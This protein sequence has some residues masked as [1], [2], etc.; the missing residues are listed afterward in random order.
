M[1]LLMK[2]QLALGLLACILISYPWNANADVVTIS[3]RQ[4]LVNGAPYTI[5][6][7]CYNPVPKYTDKVSFSNLTEDLA[8]MKE[9]GINT[10]RVYSPIADKAVLDEINAAGLKVIMGFGYNQGGKYDILS[11]SFVNLVNTYKNHGAILFW[12]L[13]NEYNY[14]AEWFGG[15]IQTWYRALNGAVELI[16]NTDPFHPVSTAC[17]GI[18]DSNLLTVCPNV[19]VWGM[20]VYSWDNPEGIF[21]DWS[22][23]SSKPMYLSETGAD[24]YMTIKANGYEQGENEKAQ[25]DADRKILESV[26]RHSDICSGVTL[27]EFADEWWKAG[28]SKK[29][30]QGGCAP[31]SCGV[32]YDGAA[33]EEYWGI[34]TTDRHKKLAFEVVKE[35][36]TDLT[37][38][39]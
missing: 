3:G 22:A 23:R 8:L 32:P 33:N 30:D 11:G 37:K 7:V 5:K 31:N 20:N 16:H 13:G 6:G 34:L 14:H 17:G 9:A 21:S 35:K 15:D 18:P 29:Q 19:D 28:D 4:I 39:K 38:S 24:S 27:F 1:L 2:K 26:F 12:E 36:Y 10:I 25:A